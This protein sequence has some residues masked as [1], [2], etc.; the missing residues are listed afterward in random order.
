MTTET[1]PLA[2]PP[3]RRTDDILTTLADRLGGRF[4]ASTVFG[5]PVER[6]GVTVIPVA[7]VRLGFGGGSGGDRRSEQ[8]GDGG[9]GGGSGTA[10]GY[11]EIRD[12]YSRFVPVVHPARMLAMLC[13]TAVA[14]A[15]SLRV[16]QAR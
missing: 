9:G 8:S 3:H 15:L 6:D 16:R 5:A 11:I 13:A 4:T 7:T 10:A 14:M 1:R 12:G 2:E